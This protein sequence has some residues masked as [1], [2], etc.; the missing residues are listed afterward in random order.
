MPTTEL[1]RL[2]FLT[3]E[4]TGLFRPLYDQILVRE[5][6]PEERIGSIWVPENVQHGPD[7]DKYLS[8]GVVVA[9][10]PGD[11]LKQK[12]PVWQCT[13]CGNEYQEIPGFRSEGPPCCGMAAS[14]VCVGEKN[15]RARMHVSPGDTIIFDRPSNRKIKLDGEVYYV[16]HEEQHVLAVIGTK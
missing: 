15:V 2:T 6:A 1:A 10:G 3:Q 16:C 8:R 7:G 5:L 12:R 9:C 13:L 11:K 4:F 14:S